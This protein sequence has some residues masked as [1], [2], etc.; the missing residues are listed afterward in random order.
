MSEIL[1][2][3]KFF[4]AKAFGAGLILALCSL[5]AFA[6]PADKPKQAEIIFAQAVKLVDENTVEAAEASLPKFAEAHRLFAEAGNTEKK[7]EAADYLGSILQKLGDAYLKNEELEKAAEYFNRA[8]PFHREIE[9]R[10]GEAEVFHNLGYIAFRRKEPEKATAFYEQAL[11]AYR[12][13]KNAIGEAAILRNLGAAYFNRKDYEGAAKFYEQA[14]VI[15]RQ[16]KDQSQE[17]VLLKDIGDA[18]ESLRK[19]EKAAGFFEQALAVYREL[20]DKVGEASALHSLGFVHVR[21]DKYKEAIGYYEQAL[22]AYRAAKNAGGEAT[23]ERNLGLI[24]YNQSKFALAVPRFERSL[25]LRRQLADRQGEVV[26]LTDLGDT[27]LME[28]NLEKAYPFFEQA[29]AIYRELKDRGGE[30]DSLNKLAQAYYDG[31]KTVKAVPLFEQALLIYRTDANRIGEAE[32][33]LKLARSQAVARRYPE[34]KSNYNQAI[35]MFRELKDESN[36]SYAL[37]NLGGL[38]QELHEFDRAKA[39]FEQALLIFRRIKDRNGEGYTLIAT[40]EFDAY[41]NRYDQAVAGIKQAQEIFRNLKDPIGEYATHASLGWVQ[42]SLSQYEES[43][44]SNEQALKIA[45]ELKDLNRQKTIL[46]NTGIIYSALGQYDKSIPIDEEVLVLSRNTGD[47]YSESIALANIGYD[48]FKQ[49][50][51]E[52]A[53]K[54]IEQSIVLMRE[55][56]AK[57]EEGYSLH[58]LGLVYYKLK[59][60]EQALKLYD[61]SLKIYHEVK[62]RRPESFLYDSYGEVYR[63]MGQFEK[64]AEN[65]EKA[66]ILSREIKYSNVEAN[67]LT[68]L[69]ILWERRKQPRLAAFYGKQAVNVFQTIRGGNR[70]LDKEAQKSFLKSN[71]ET[72]RRLADLLIASGRLIEAQQIL[73]MLKEEEFYGFVR[74][75]A[76]EIEKLSQRADLTADETEALKRYAAVSSRVTEIGAEF[77]KLQDAKNLLPDGAPLAAA[78]QKRY[79][80][81]AK[82]LEDSTAAFQVFLRGLA[83]EFTKKPKVVAE[84]Q[85]NTGLQA[86]LKTWGDGIVALYTVVGEDRYRVIL[87]TPDAQTDGKTEISAEDLNRK[88]SEFRQAVQNPNADPRPLG[89]EL[90]DILIKPIEKQLA[91]AK[92]KTLLWSLDGTL[93]Y[94]PIAAL[95]DGERYFGQKYENVVITLASRTRLGET[96]SADWRVL[97]LGVTDAK[98]V[99]EPSGTQQINFSALPAVRN[100]LRAIVSDETTRENSGGVMPGVILMNENFTEAAFKDRLGKGYKV[101]HIAS[102][103]SFRPGNETNSFLLL[104][105]GSAL[106]LVKVRTSPQLKFKGVELLTLSACQ[107]AVGET[108]ATGKEIES[109]GEI[110]Q[111]NGAKAVLATLWSVADE[112]TQLLIS[113]F[114]RLRKENPGVTKSEAMRLAQKAMIEGKLQSSTEE[115]KRRAELAGATATNKNLPAFVKD[116]TKPFAH[117]FYWSPFVL[118]GNWR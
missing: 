28:K 100:E 48:S 27:F 98:A 38:F 85:E 51:Y 105:D 91:D 23:I 89:K 87:T 49:A 47:K 76:S 37:L 107:T 101:I 13:T 88:I 116:A 43:F 71:E 24:Y 14:L 42:Y 6:Q 102:H 54:Y 5:F 65:L 72:Y 90:Y 16:L 67:A 31:F 118:I 92:A 46:I 21:L 113:E 3:R 44:K 12:E 52:K 22:T 70:N 34:A 45:R 30:L 115:T 78:D 58:N 11:T 111:Q 79:D 77:G 25:V 9:N 4:A 56:N 96:V 17:A 103:F 8:L 83:E 41:F 66:L 82:Q 106:S 86:D 57:R 36:E 80:E 68:N 18:F 1:I 75:D 84:I 60:Y 112:S 117:P 61:Q 26:L 73:D 15:R 59:N 20:K 74:R 33:L 53:K 94:L 63:D 32:T 55:Q 10:E 7:N 104:G 81:L 19:Y 109:F 62:D 97:G 93:R 29:L 69:M 2:D 108:D 114:Y 110:A 64:A 35:V 95:W 50:D 40:A 39:S 99:L